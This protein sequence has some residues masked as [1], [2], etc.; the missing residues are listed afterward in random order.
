MKKYDYD[1]WKKMTWDWYAV[2]DLRTVRYKKSSKSKGVFRLCDVCDF[3][4]SYRKSILHQYTSIPKIHLHKATCPKC[5]GE[6]V[7][8]VKC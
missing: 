2:P 7:R 5:L 4:F 8:L 3:V 6:D 1:Y